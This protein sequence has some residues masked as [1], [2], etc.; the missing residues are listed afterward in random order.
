[1]DAVFPC[2]LLD[3]LRGFFELVLLLFG[4]QVLWVHLQFPQVIIHVDVLFFLI[5]AILFVN[6]SELPSLPHQGYQLPFVNGLP[7]LEVIDDLVRSVL[8]DER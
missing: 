8:V 1:M 3:A 4:V 5:L 6:G 7:F 2:E